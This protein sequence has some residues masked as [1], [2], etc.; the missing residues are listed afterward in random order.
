[1][2]SGE[3]V[4]QEL[5]T[6]PTASSLLS[7]PTATTHKATPDR[8]SRCRLPLADSL[9]EVG[10]SPVAHRLVVLVLLYRVHFRCGRSG[11]FR[12]SPPRLA[13]TRLLQVL[14][15]PTVANGRGFSP[16]RSVCAASQRTSAGILPAWCGRGSRIRGTGCPRS[17][18]LTHF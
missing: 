7:C 5:L 2:A 8:A 18:N 12:C 1:M 9:A 14:I 3:K 6:D 4:C 17:C 13:A 15:S 11:S 10:T 16:R